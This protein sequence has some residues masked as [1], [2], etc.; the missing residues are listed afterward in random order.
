MIEEEKREEE[1][2]KEELPVAPENDEPLAAQIELEEVK[3]AD[4]VMEEQV[5]EEQ[6]E[7]EI[8]EEVEVV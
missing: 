2:Y 4:N 8:Q 6:K 5:V 7:E 1:E 3:E